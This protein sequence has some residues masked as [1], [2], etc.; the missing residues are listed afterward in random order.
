MW[1]SS[2]WEVT[3]CCTVCFFFFIQCKLGC[4]C[5]VITC[6]SHKKKLTIVHISWTEICPGIYVDMSYRLLLKDVVF[7][8]F[9]LWMFKKRFCYRYLDCVFFLSNILTLH[10]ILELFRFCLKVKLRFFFFFFFNNTDHFVSFVIDL[11]LW[12]TVTVKFLLLNC[13]FPFFVFFK[14]H[15]CLLVGIKWLMWLLRL[16]LIWLQGY[17]MILHYAKSLN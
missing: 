4:S 11:T 6:K 14:L 10:P 7:F 13:C 15:I 5:I 9:S 17:G 8:F 12:V 2:D 3:M 16:G 1:L